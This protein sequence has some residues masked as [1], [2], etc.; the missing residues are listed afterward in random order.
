MP[1]S[2]ANRVDEH[3][4]HVT[5]LHSD[6]FRLF[7]AVLAHGSGCLL[8]YSQK[9]TSSTDGSRAVISHF[10]LKKRL[11]I[12]LCLVGSS[13]SLSS[14]VWIVLDLN[15]NPYQ[16]DPCFYSAL[17]ETKIKVLLGCMARYHMRVMSAVNA[18]S[19][20]VVF[21]FL[22]CLVHVLVVLPMQFEVRPFTQYPWGRLWWLG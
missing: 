9:V 11:A 3:F 19:Q 4:V 20:S 10:R 1:K 18:V 6:L 8:R 22:E 5:S 17:R 12:L 13:R 21:C 15:G 16:F 14:T 7:T 2:T